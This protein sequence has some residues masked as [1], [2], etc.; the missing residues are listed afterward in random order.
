MLALVPSYRQ[1]DWAQRFAPYFLAGVAVVSLGFV[2]DRALRH[3][4]RM[5]SCRACCSDAGFRDSAT[6]PEYRSGPYYCVCISATRAAD[7]EVCR[8]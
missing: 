3:R 7:R 8:R 6:L 2:V 1:N 4:A 5:S